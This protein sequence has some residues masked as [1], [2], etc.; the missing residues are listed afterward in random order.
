MND[1]RGEGK[2]KES[3]AVCKISGSQEGIDDEICRA[4][5]LVRVLS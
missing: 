1:N 2:Q 3:C 5:C 4:S